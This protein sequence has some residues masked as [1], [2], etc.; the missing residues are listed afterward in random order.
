MRS[1]LA[2]S[3]LA[4]ALLAATAAED[5]AAVALI[6]VGAD[7]A[8]PHAA[9]HFTAMRDDVVNPLAAD[10]FIVADYCPGGPQ[11]VLANL[12]RTYFGDR[13]RGV[14]AMRPPHA[15][16]RPAAG[17][18]AEAATPR[19]HASVIQW[20]RLQEGWNQME[21]FERRRGA[22]YPAPRGDPR[23]RL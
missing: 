9:A 5:P 3:A 10:V 21:A 8:Q 23:P 22:A 2:A 16:V 7:R 11:G 14:V 18:C 15:D 4:A 6:L 1:A 20:A 13:V 12:A 17:A 19:V